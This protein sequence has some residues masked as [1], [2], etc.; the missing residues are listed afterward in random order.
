MMLLKKKKLYH[1]CLCIGKSIVYTA[2]GTICS[3]RHL[4]AEGLGTDS[5]QMVAGWGTTLEMELLG[6]TINIS[7]YLVE[8]SKYYFEVVASVYS[9]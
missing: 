5:S 7:L 8:N 4:S 2:F 1:R 9:H 3:F 6:H